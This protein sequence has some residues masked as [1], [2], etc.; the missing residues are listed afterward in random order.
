MFTESI[1]AIVTATRALFKSRRTLVL[2]LVAY[3]GLLAA[4]YLFVST[5]EATISQLVLTVT[6]VIVAPALFFLLQALSVS[7][8]TGAPSQ[9]L[10]RKCFKLIVVSVPLIGITLLSLY[11]LNKVDSNVTVVTALRYLLIAVV[12]PLLAIQLWIGTSL[13]RAFAPQPVFVYALGFLIFAVA[14][15]FLIIKTIPTE[16]AWLE[17]S[18]LL[19]RLSTAAVLVLLGWV[20]TV[21]AIAVLNHRNE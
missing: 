14:P 6:L 7:Y 15:Y 1:N 19:L 10:S 4:V 16:R 2:M 13:R 5:R 11:G 9:G 12:A 18:L 17:V 8:A 20:T 3:A 21:G